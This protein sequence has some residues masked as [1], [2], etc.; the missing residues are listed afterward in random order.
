MAR[1]IGATRIA[2]TNR[3]RLNLRLTLSSSL[4][5]V[6]GEWT[7]AR[8]KSIWTDTVLGLGRP[9]HC[10]KAPWVKWGVSNSLPRSVKD[11]YSLM[12]LS[13]IQIV[14]GIPS[15]RELKQ[16]APAYFVHIKNAACQ[17]LI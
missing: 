6:R 10:S 11:Q 2:K 15:D 12:Y 17:K 8:R 16:C 4:M 1:V 14:G 13:G 9:A 5:A 3:R 7:I